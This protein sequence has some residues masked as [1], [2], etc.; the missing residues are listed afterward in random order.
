MQEV[1]I[2][3]SVWTVKCQVSIHVLQCLLYKNVFT[4]DGHRLYWFH[5]IDQS[6]HSLFNFYSIIF[7]VLVLVWVLIV[8]T[9]CSSRRCSNSFLCS[10]NF[11]STQV[12]RTEEFH[13]GQLTEVC[14]RCVSVCV[15]VSAWEC[16]CVPA[17]TLMLVSVAWWF[18]LLMFSIGQA[19]WYL[20]DIKDWWCSTFLYSNV[21]GIHHIN[22]KWHLV[23]HVLLQFTLEFVFSIYI[24]MHCDFFLSLPDAD[25]PLFFL[26]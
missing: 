12:E 18:I 9:N 10:V 19:Q 21:P 3:R 20:S 15:R 4:Y 13:T 23:F 24:L 2:G 11:L 6:C 1:T 22:L 17:F 14:R 8:H 25:W 7:S 16:A 26:I 5:F